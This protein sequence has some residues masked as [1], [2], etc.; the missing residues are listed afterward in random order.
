MRAIS[1][2][3]NCDR[4]ERFW[5]ANADWTWERYGECTADKGDG[6]EKVGESGSGMDPDT[7]AAPFRAL[8]RF[9]LAL[10]GELSSIG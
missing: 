2:N 3:C 8:A 4:L 9:D 6:E 1:S 10:L 5:D 7:F